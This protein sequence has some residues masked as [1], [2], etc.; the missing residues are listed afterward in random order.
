MVE[1]LLRAG[2]AGAVEHLRGQRDARY[3]GL[4]LVG[5]VVDEV[6][7][8][9]RVLLLPEDGDDGE[10]EREEQHDGEDDARNHESHA[11]VDVL[12]H[13][14]EVDFH[15]APLGLRVVVEEHLLVAILLALVGVVGAAVDLASVLCGDGEVVGDVDAIVH[16]LGLEVLVEELEV[17]AFLERLLRCGIDDGQH[18]LVEQC[19][20]VDVAVLDD[21]L[22]GL[23]GLVV[24]LLVV[25]QDHG[26]GHLRGLGHH[27]LGLEGGVAVR[28]L[29]H[30]RLVGGHQRAVGTQ[31][32][33]VALVVFPLHGVDVLLQVAERLVEFQVAA[34][35]IEGTVDAL[36]ELLLLHV[37]HLTDVGELHEKQHDERQSHHYCYDPNRSLLHGSKVTV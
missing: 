23:G 15:D 21:F 20:L 31:V 22:Q 17:D 3:R 12:R 24:R 2:H 1:H 35:L 8:H 29:R 5:H 7:L 16:Q 18:H 26:L 25:V 9:L 4:Q 30:R 37:D 6:V 32:D 27:R 28:V 10:D 19:L 13:V 33:G 36:V 14:G 34:G 11:G